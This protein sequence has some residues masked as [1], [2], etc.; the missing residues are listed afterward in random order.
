MRRRLRELDRQH[1]PVKAVRRLGCHRAQREAE[2]NLGGVRFHRSVI[3]L[4]W[5]MF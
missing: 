5:F 2:N 4:F 1:G 3:R